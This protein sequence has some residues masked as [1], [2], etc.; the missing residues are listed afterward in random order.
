MHAAVEA[1]VNS[2]SGQKEWRLKNALLYAMAVASTI[3]LLDMR[4]SF[5]PS[6]I[7]YLEKMKCSTKNMKP[8]KMFEFPGNMRI[9]R[10][11]IT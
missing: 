7:G 11:L 3:G 6:I 1:G 10:I 5:V 2:Y 9:W 4:I 8:V